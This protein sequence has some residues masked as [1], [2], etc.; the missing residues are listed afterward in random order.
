MLFLPGRKLISWSAGHTRRRPIINHLQQITKLPHGRF[1]SSKAPPRMTLYDVIFRPYNVYGKK[2]SEKLSITN[3]VLAKEPPGTS[4]AVVVS[5]WRTS[6][7]EK[8]LHCTVDYVD[9]RRRRLIR[10][11]IFPKGS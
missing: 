10:D 1:K 6:P 11:H 3:L 7:G 9:L 4:K 2:V 8:K 5:G